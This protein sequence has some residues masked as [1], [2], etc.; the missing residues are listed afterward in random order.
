MR[1]WIKAGRATSYSTPGVQKWISTT[2]TFGKRLEESDSA[3]HAGSG[4]IASQVKTEA[5]MQG[6]VSGEKQPSGGWRGWSR[7]SQKGVVRR[8]DT[9]GRT[10]LG[11]I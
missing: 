10:S 3:S 1:E 9:W 4:E 11:L 8:G 5:T 2:G 6:H 7:E